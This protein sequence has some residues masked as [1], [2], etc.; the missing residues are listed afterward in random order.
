MGSS[1]CNQSTVD[2]KQ[3]KTDGSGGG[4]PEGSVLPAAEG[5]CQGGWHETSVNENAR[6]GQKVKT[7]ATGHFEGVR[8]DQSGGGSPGSA[9]EGK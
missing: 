7:R 2:Q 8:F 9:D 5:G 4:S 1:P 6:H 3:K